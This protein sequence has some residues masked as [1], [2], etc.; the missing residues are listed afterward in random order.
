METNKITGECN[1]VRCPD[2]MRPFK[3]RQFCRERLQTKNGQ[4]S[5]TQQAH[6]DQTDV[7]AIVARFERTGVMGHQTQKQPQYGDVT[8]LQGDLV[9][10]YNDSLAIID[11]AE[12][13]AAKWQS[14]M[15]PVDSNE[16]DTGDKKGGQDPQQK[17][18]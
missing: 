10:R 4:P 16:K 18:E 15:D 1:P 9:E 7:N 14:K 6:L 3:R 11:Q 12:K 5:M 17:V 8:G 2:S 13:F